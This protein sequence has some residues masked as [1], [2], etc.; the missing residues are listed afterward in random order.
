MKKIKKIIVLVSTVILSSVGPI[1]G[2]AE[3]TAKTQ[4]PTVTEELPLS[5]SPVTNDVTSTSAVEDSFS[6]EESEKEVSSENS[7]EISASESSLT[8]ATEVTQN[9]SEENI[10]AE[11]DESDG[12]LADAEQANEDLSQAAV[13]KAIAEMEILNDVFPY[14]KDRSDLAES[15][16][17]SDTPRPKARAAALTVEPQ[18]QIAAAAAARLEN[19]YADSDKDTPTMDFVDVSSHNGEISVDQYKTLKKYGVKA[20]IVKL[21]E[22]TTYRNPYAKSQINNAKAAGLVV[23]GYHY[24]WFTSK[25]TAEKEAEYFAKYA[26]ELKLGNNAIMFNDIED[27]QLY[28][29]NINH[30]QNS[31]YFADALK[32]LGYN[33]S[34]HYIGQWWVRAGKLDPAKLGY[35]KCWIAEYPIPTVKE[36]RNTQYGAWQW[37]SQVY[38]PGKNFPFD[39]SSDYS[40]TITLPYGE[41]GPYISLGKYF[42][43]TAKNNAIWSSFKWA[44]KDRTDNHL[45]KTYYAKGMYKHVNGGT[46]LSLYDNKDKW[47]GYV[48][49][50]FGTL[51]DGPGGKWAS[52]KKYVTLNQTKDLYSDFTSKIKNKASSYKN[53]QLL[54]TG[55]YEHFNGKTYYSVYTADS[56]TW[57][58]YVEKS[59]VTLAGDQGP[60]L[61]LGKYFTITG[62]NHTIWSNFNWTKRSDAKSHLGK[63][64]LAKGQYKHLNGSTYLTLYD[65]QDKWVGYI[66]VSGGKLTTSAGGSWSSY[67]KYLTV[68]GSKHLYAGDFTKTIKNKGSVYK[69]KTLLATG[70]YEHFNGKT[71]YSVYENNTWLGY[72]EEAGVKVAGDQGPYVKLGKYFTITGKNHKIWS[73]FDWKLRKNASELLGKTY[74]AKGQYKHLN[75]STY[76]TLYDNKGKWVGYINANGGK[77]GTNPGGAWSSYKITV[78][79]NGTKNLYGGDFTK[80]VK[81]KASAFKNQ[82]LSVTGKYEHYNGKTYYS[83]YNSK[84]QWLGYIESSGVKKV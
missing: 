48:N 28:A 22:Y 54:V 47:I 71:Y 62:K 61:A 3:T 67:K 50:A 25:S 63:T 17:D 24:S 72:V 51:T 6:S 83:V 76:L 34:Q 11:T 39:M 12:S 23:H 41:Q 43:I 20:V 55:K 19:I 27:P 16:I 42:T 36:Q 7:S 38:I 14:L 75:G 31:I 40:K 74:L 33:N 15:P 13:E 64:Y 37:T 59:G 77:Q 58:G 45:N 26:D 8:S 2:L 49:A 46:Y 53:K 60:Y 1:T 9:S 30:T 35:N 78:T 57:L 84:K 79:L 52:Y 56:K 69:G 4:S 10:P 73:N 29:K 66:N 65:N 32:K 21:T 70:K 68:T 5:G 44:Q 18:E 82:K 81:N 80:T